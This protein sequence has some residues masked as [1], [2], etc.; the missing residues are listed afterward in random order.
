MS[1][2]SEP[3]FQIKIKEYFSVLWLLRSTGGVYPGHEYGPIRAVVS[4]QGLSQN[5]CSFS[6]TYLC[7]QKHL[8]RRYSLHYLGFQECYEHINKIRHY[9][10]I[11][12]NDLY[13]VFEE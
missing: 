11:H 1:Y 4:H 6:E 13:T 9:L 7:S 5:L 2:F 3:D 10:K 12:V 8:L